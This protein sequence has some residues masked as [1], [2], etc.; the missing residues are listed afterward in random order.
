M[1]D[2]QGITARLRG[3]PV[4]ERRL[5]AVVLLVAASFLAGWWLGRGGAAG[6][7]PVAGP[8][9]GPAATITSSG[10]AEVTVPPD[11]GQEVVTE[12]S[13]PKRSAA[14][15]I[16]FPERSVPP[17]PVGRFSCPQAS[18]TVHTATEF[19]HALDLAGPGT[20]IGLADGRYEGKFALRAGGTEQAP[21]YV[22]G[23]RDAVLDGGGIKGGYV[24]HLDGV[25]AVR[26]AGFTVRNG[27][28]GVVVDGGTAV[29][30]Q[31]L[32]VEHLGDEAVH[33]R[34]HTTRSVV[35]GLTIRDTGNRREKFGEGVYIGTAVSNWP[36]ITDGLPD[37]SDGNHVLDNRISDTTSE[38]VD[39]KEGTSSGVL[40]G[41]EFDGAALAGADSWVDVKGNG[42]LIVG[43]RG[44]ASL[45]DGFQTHVILPGWGDL[46]RFSGNTAEVDGPGY[47]FYLHEQHGNRIDCD[48]TVS[49]AVRGYANHP[50]G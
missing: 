14:A 5:V 19:Q 16:A 46:N 21:V 29:A 35:R 4:R 34:R 47:G 27:Q 49:G 38:S 7:D 17:P 48:N 45:E 18:V 13:S 12:T 11:T 31:D 3:L 42:W 37:R 22:C 40:S 8:A 26:L 41:N 9:A 30:L 10:S 50:C 6:P 32:L 33:L 2:R 24:L 44:R 1:T 43:N 28:K 39:I 36:T 15:V 25:A 23:S 20:V